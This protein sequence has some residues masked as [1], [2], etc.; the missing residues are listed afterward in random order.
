MH[1]DTDLGG[2]AA[3][4]PLTR[5]SLV[6]AAGNGDAGVRR[7]AFADLVEAYW[8]PVYKYLRLKRGLGNEDAKDLTQAFFARAFE[9]GY[10][11]HFDPSRARFRTFLRVCLDRFT[12]SEY[13][14]QTSQRRGGDVVT[15]SL[16]FDAA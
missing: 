9:K 4:F 3:A 8:K 11:D 16:D 7:R 6:R 12:A 15:L 1:D 5:G 13:R 10:F 14:S 2:P